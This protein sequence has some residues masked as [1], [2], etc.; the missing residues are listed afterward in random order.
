MKLS[1]AE[2]M[3]RI[4]MA[5]DDAAA[6]VAGL[7]QKG[8]FPNSVEIRHGEEIKRRRFVLPVRRRSGA[9]LKG[10][11]TREWVLVFCNQR[12]IFAT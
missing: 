8:I 1:V 5:P 9:P 3:A 10:D 7:K 6:V 2:V 12:F 11:P 4:E